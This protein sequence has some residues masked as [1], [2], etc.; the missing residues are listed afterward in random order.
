MKL[1]GNIVK[2]EGNHATVEFHAATSC[3]GWGMASDS[4]VERMQQITIKNEI[5]AQLGDTV[6]F[7]L[8]TVIDLLFINKNKVLIFLLSGGIAIF[9]MKL[10]QSTTAIASA[11]INIIAILAMLAIYSV[12]V[13]LFGLKEDAETKS[14]SVI[15][16]TEI[17]AKNNDHIK[18]L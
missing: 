7:N 15:K 8:P 3:G 2:I 11:I 18:Q 6:K 16:M 1:T 14:N 5:G 4:Q 10:L 12:A 13:R 9:I 17:V